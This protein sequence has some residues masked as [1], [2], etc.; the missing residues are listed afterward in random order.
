VAP[1]GVER[2]RA[3]FDYQWS[4]LPQNR[5]SLASPEFRA[6]IP[7]RLCA[8]TQLDR[9]WFKGKHI[10]D[11]GC[12]MG[13]HAFG[14]CA[15]GAS[16]TAVDRS[17]AALEGTR[18]ACVG[19]PNFQGAIA[20][21]LLRPLPFERRFDLV[22]SYGSLHHTGDTRAAFRNVARHVAPGGVTFVML[23]GAPR[24]VDDERRIASLEA[25]R[26]RFRGKPFSEIVE[27]LRQ[28]PA[29]DDV[30]GYFDM[31]SPAINDRHG[32][33]ELRRW[34]AEEGLVGLRR[35][36]DEIDHY[37]IARRPEA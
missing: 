15:L 33:E 31:L 11:A 25:W 21:D 24:N 27:A 22:W 7:G 29:V 4:R 30:I 36:V 1:G 18:A 26:A 17:L 3:S 16:V 14:F 23:Y 2:T 6:E 35:R 34:F 32:Y 37:L 8:L 28:A 13:R 5:W 12:G 9:E 19:F 10:L 20:A